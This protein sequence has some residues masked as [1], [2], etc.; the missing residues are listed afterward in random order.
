MINTTAEYALRA[1]VYL[2]SAENDTLGR[3]LI[4]E[5]TQIPSNYLV[6]VM[7]MLEVAGIIQSRRGPGG[8]YRLVC[9]PNDLSVYD[10]VI[11]V[12]GFQRI[13]SCPLG[14][15][16][17]IHLCPLHARL[18]AVA[19][20]AEQALRQ[21]SISDLIPPAKKGPQCIFPKTGPAED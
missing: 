5:H 3:T 7:K 14:I 1:V 17:H 12:S 19:A 13:E 4:V 16:E 15:R 21:T 2:A 11:A 8:G 6:K 18:D 9:E 20:L 10:V